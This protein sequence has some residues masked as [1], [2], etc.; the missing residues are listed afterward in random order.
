LDEHGPGQLELARSY[1]GAPVFVG[2]GD[3]ARIPPEWRGRRRHLAV[4]LRPGAEIHLYATQPGPEVTQAGFGYSVYA[5]EV[6]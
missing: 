4:W 5:S 6:A 3:D 2:P 1:W